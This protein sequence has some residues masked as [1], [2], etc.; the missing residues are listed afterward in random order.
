MDWC[1]KYN[2]DMVVG[3]HDHVRNVVHLGNTTYLTM[4]ALLDNYDHAGFLKLFFNQGEIE[5]E[6]MNL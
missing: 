5:F 3:A 2:I 4:D 6:F 1:V